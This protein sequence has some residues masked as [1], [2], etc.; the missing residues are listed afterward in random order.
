MFDIG[1]LELLILGIVGLLVLGPERLPKAA[2]TA[3]LW[4]GKIKRT[5]SSMQ[6]EINSQLEAEELRQKL[7]EQQSKLDESLNKAKRDVESIAQ[8]YS[9]STPRKGD[10][11]APAT[12]EHKPDDVAP[13]PSASARLDEALAEVRQSDDAPSS[14]PDDDKD[15][16]SR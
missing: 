1:F 8:P 3:G 16:A 14:P 4:V 5:V 6:R 15:A 10:D 12:P 2:R 7:K 9:T 13:P 11:D